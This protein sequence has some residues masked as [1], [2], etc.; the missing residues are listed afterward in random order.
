MNT[1]DVLA[2]VAEHRDDRGVE[3]WKELGLDASGLTSYGVGLTQ[4]RALAKRV[5]RNRDLAVS[6][7]QSDVYEARVISLL[8]D[9][10]RAITREQAE[11]Q[12]E[13][14]DVGMLSHV[15]SSCGSSLAKAPFVVELVDQWTASADV[16]RRSCGY[17]LLYEVAQLNGKKAPEDAYFLE[18]IERIDRAIRGER[19]E[20]QLAMAAALMNIGKRN[21]VLNAAALRVARKVGPIEFD[22]SSGRC[23]PF[24]V[25]KH[26]TTDRL[27]K[28][29]GL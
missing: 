15:F 14:V 5:G 20:V 7:W 8:I 18:H 17:G 1:T 2:L 12:V 3:K 13:Q 25:V 4:L 16:R 21:A 29:L 27:K 24:D 11:S 26:L 23:E 22:S 6:L 10:P 9:D 19:S 28:K